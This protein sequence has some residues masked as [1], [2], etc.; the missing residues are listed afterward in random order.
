[1]ATIKDIAK[2]AHVST[3]TVSRVLNTPDAVSEERRRRVLQA[4]ERLNYT[5]NA[6]ARELKTNRT[7][8]VGILLPDITNTFTPTVIESFLQVMNRHGYN[9]LLCITNADPQLEFEYI[10]M[11]NKKRVEGFVFLGSRC[12]SQQNDDFIEHIAQKLPVIATDY[13]DKPSVS[14]IMADEEQG[15]YLAARHLLALGHRRIAFLNG[16][17][18]RYTTYY[19]KQE[20]FF[21]AVHEMSAD[22]SACSLVTVQPNYLGGYEAACQLFEQPE[23]PTAVFTAGDQIAV[24][25]YRAAQEHGLPIPEA[26]SVIGFSG[27]PISMSVYPPMTT[28]SQFAQETGEQA[29]R[30]MLEILQNAPSAPRNLIFTPELVLRQSCAPP[31]RESLL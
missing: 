28:V 15:A 7:G 17:H 21:R 25:V 31:Q 22:L 26:L 30:L 23:R 14:H 20:G 6:L 4:I 8:A 1:M 11:M 9:T 3:A 19:Y 12:F 27:S 13:L 5:P 10:R 18:T 16:D 2:T 29:A 24:G